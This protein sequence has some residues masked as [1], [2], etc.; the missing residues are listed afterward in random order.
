METVKQRQKFPVLEE[1]KKFLLELSK[2]IIEENIKEDSI[3]IEK[4]DE[5]NDKISIKEPKNITLKKFVIDEMGYTLNDKG[6]LP[7]Y[8]YYVKDDY[9]HIFIELPG[10]GKIN[11]KVET[12][13]GYYL[14][15]FEG[16]KNGDKVIEEDCKK[17]KSELV[18]SKSTR[19]TTKFKFGIRIP[20]TAFRLISKDAEK[21]ENEKG[22]I[23]YKYKISID[24]NEVITTD[25]F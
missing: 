22:V 12:I 23:E 25:E 17:T 15:T 10:G 9:F 11:K 13:Q 19:K 7:K 18:C 8:S 1:C 6:S 5:N 21:P 20:N 14:F 16:F 24:K 4:I 3:Y 2:E